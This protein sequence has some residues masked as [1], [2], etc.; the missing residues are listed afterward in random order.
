MKKTG[1]DGFLFGIL[2]AIMFAYFF[3]QAGLMQKPFSLE[4]VADIG[5]TIVFLFYGLKL[6]FD[7]LKNGVSNWRMHLVI[8]FTTFIYFPLLL[9]C[10]KPFFA[11]E[12][13]KEIWLGIFY[14]S[15]LPS[16]VAS[17]VVMVGIAGG[18]V[19]AAIFNASLSSFIGIFIT[20][21]WV[22][23]VVA[24]SS[25]TADTS[26]IITKLGL[27]VLLPVVLGLLLNKRFGA[28]ANKHKSR[29]KYIDQST[30]LLVI[31]ISF[32]HSFS[33]HI[34]SDFRWW[35][36][37]LLGVGMIALFFSTMALV[38]LVSKPFG[39]N[40]KDRITVLFCGSKKSLIHGTV[41]SK[42]LLPA[43]APVGIILLPLMLYHAL[44][45]ILSSVIAQRIA[46]IE[47]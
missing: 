19:A 41:M 25:Q 39:F 30:I 10:L 21:L 5:I 8:Q 12:H 26:G 18:N 29:L 22:G 46:K 31:Y 43:A 13:A 23:L 45:L 28:W 4:T 6:N 34:F 9:L 24:A 36:L 38:F 27:Q 35:E 15:A 7:D 33:S 37:L 16:T 11:S 42:V 40:L 47:K 17:A 1:I 20:P 32:C 2:V 14:L 3:P 44:Q